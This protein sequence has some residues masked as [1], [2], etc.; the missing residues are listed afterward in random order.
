MCGRPWFIHSL[1]S[2]RRLCPVGRPLQVE[3]GRIV[4]VLGAVLPLQPH[5]GGDARRRRSAGAST[6][7]A[8]APHRLQGDQPARGSAPT[9]RGR[10]P[11]TTAE[12][13]RLPLQQRARA[14]RH[15]RTQGQGTTRHLVS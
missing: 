12:A 8:A 3:R 14:G 4:G 11:T 6:G 2:H 1:Q 7:A 9:G 10:R 13:A 5:P 15:R